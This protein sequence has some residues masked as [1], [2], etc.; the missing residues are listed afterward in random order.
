MKIKKLT[1]SVLSLALIASV[2]G[3]ANLDK[4]DDA[5]L[6]A[7]EDYA[8]A[9]SKVKVS[10]ITDLLVDGDD[11]EDSIEDLI[12][13]ALAQEVPEGF[14][15]MTDAIADTIEYEVDEG[16]VESSKKNAEASVDVTF[17][18]V[19]YATIFETVSDNGG[20]VEDYI[21]ELKSS[22]ADTIE[23][24]QT[25]D[26]VL[27]DGEWKIQ[28]NR[29]K[30]LNKVYGFYL[31][32]LDYIFTAP[33]ASYIDYIEWYYSSDSVYTNVTQ[34]ELDI[35]TTT[36]GQEEEFEF[37]YE[38]YYNGDL[39]YTS[40]EWD[41]QGHWIE[42]Y[43]GPFYDSNAPVNTDGTLAAGSYRCV[44]YDLDGHVLADS[45][46]TVE[47][48]D[49]MTSGDYI[50]Y[51]EWYFSDD[52]VYT[53]VETIELDI[54]PTEGIGQAMTWEFTY[55]YYLDGELIYTSDE[56]EDSGYWIENYY[57]SFYDSGAELTDE[58][59]LI[60]GEYTCIMYDLDGNILAQDTC[61]VEVE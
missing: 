11:A 33:L 28:D 27:V 12:S 52:G 56:H 41:N 2:S 59:Y 61:T 48:I 13:G 4:D 15:D 49:A 5:V 45:T 38:Y 26:L 6:A 14:G 42:A 16:S 40:D 17:T 10:D 54:I 43:Y 22:D 25:L 30:N 20:N 3:C 46:C 32:A 60:P 53:N 47:H 34:I 24:T 55:E 1:A 37:T 23:I 57:S 8:E 51:I 18:M 58:G 44:I 19:D 39:I 29:L 21:S 35:V 31:D 50:D 36:D 9:I 7:A